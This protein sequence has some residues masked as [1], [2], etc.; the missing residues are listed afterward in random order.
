[1]KTNLRQS[2]FRIEKSKN[3][4][5]DKSCVKWKRYDIR[6]IVRKIKNT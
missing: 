5:V 1:M 3:K 4:N 2:E 6:L